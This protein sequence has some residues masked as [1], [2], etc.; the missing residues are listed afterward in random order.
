M[1]KGR[2]KSVKKGTLTGI[3]VGPGDPELITIKAI[4]LLEECDFVVIPDS[5]KAVNAAYTIAKG[6]YPD[7]EKK[8]LLEVKMPMVRDE[9]ILK[10]HHRHAAEEIGRQLNK[11]Q[12]G[13][14]L[15]LGDPTVYAT[16]IYVHKLLEETGYETSIVPGITSFC[17]AAARMNI[18][19]TDAEKALH[20]IPASYSC[21]ES[22]MAYEGTKVLMKSGKSLGKIKEIL[23]KRKDLDVKMVERCGMEGEKVY[24]SAEE[25]DETAGYFSIIIVREK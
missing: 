7:I 4:R 11:G 9:D 2:D 23:S 24:N 14:F 16:Y 10:E 12:D 13:V 15:T 18:G 20:I 25:I 19:L 17:A 21:L 6:A 1:N 8:I 3:G 5:G 22:Q